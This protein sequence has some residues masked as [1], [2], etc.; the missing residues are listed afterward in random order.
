VA[1]I[2]PSPAPRAARRAPVASRL[3]PPLVVSRLAPPLVV[4]RLAPPLVVSRLAPPLVVSR[5]SRAL[6]LAALAGC[7]WLPPDRPATAPAPAD[8]DAAV[9]HDWKVADHVL[10]RRALISDLDAAGFHG[11]TVSVAATTYA[12]PWSGACDQA[13][14]QHTP[15]VLAEVA[16]DHE[17][18]AARLALSAPITEYRL[19]CATGSAPGLTLYVAGPHAVTCFAGVCYLLAR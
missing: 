15:R 19:S 5:L 4:S 14:R 11:R 13:N 17:V 1:P 18:D 3:A 16:L 9:L 7:G 8:P 10:A 6:A 12:S 2:R